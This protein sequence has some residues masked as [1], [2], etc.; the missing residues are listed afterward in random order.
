MA[1]QTFVVFLIIC[2]VI[3]YI[4]NESQFLNVSILSFQEIEEARQQHTKAVK[5]NIEKRKKISKALSKRTK[6]GQPVMANQIKFMLD[7]IKTKS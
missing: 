5:K 7:K 6:K 3:L 1:C 2:P 4:S